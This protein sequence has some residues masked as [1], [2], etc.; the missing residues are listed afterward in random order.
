MCTLVHSD[1]VILTYWNF[2]CV[3]FLSPVLEI[4]INQR[5]FFYII[6]VLVCLFNCV[7]NFVIF[8]YA[9]GVTFC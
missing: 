4:S 6:N 1:V 9:H 2:K 8:F 7:V 5:E 3:L